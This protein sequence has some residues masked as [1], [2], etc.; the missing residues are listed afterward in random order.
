MLYLLLHKQKNYLEY[1]VISIKSDI[2]MLVLNWAWEEV[3][4][5]KNTS[6]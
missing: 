3:E 1:C 4:W 2:F 5:R 6:M